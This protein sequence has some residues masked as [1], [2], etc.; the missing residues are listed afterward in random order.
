VIWWVAAAWAATDRL[1]ECTDAGTLF[2]DVSEQVG[3]RAH[4]NSLG[5]NLNDVDGD[6]DID[7]LVATG[8]SRAEHS[9]YLSG[10]SLLYLN[11]GDTFVEAGAEWGIDDVCEDR[12]PLFA[13]LDND[14][15]PDI[16]MTVNG[17]NLLLRNDGYST[18]EDVT[19]FAGDA[20]HAGW[21]H[22]AVLLDFDRDGLLDVFFTN[23]PEDG[24]GTNVLLRNLGDGVFLDES[25]A[26]GVAGNPSGKGA[27]VLDVDDDG[28]M[29]LF[30]TT[31]REYGNQLFMNQGDG[32]FDD[33]AVARGVSDPAKRFGVGTACEDLDNDGDPDIALITHD[34]SWTGNQLFRNDDGHFT[35][36]AAEAGVEEWVD[37]HG[38]AAVDLE[39]DG[40]LDLVLAGIGIP[41]V[42][43]QNQGDLTFTR[44][45]D[46]AGI[47][48]DE[49]VTWAV[50]AGDVLGQDGYPEVL[51]SN[52]LGRRPRS[53]EIFRNIG[54]TAHYLTVH[55][56][57]VSHNPSAV[58]ARV[59]VWVGDDVQTRWVGAFSSFDSQGPLP[60]TVGLGDAEQADRVVV[61]FTNGQEQVLQA[62][63]AD[64]TVHV[65][66]MATRA[67]DDADGVPDDW[68][69]C[70]FTA[71]RRPTDHEGCSPDQ[72]AGVSLA[73]GLPGQDAVA[74]E[75]PTWTWSG[76]ATQVVLQVGT[77]GTFGPAGRYDYGPFTDTTFSLS[78]AEWAELVEISDGWAPVIW[79][80]VG[81]GEDGAQAW[82]EPRRLYVAQPTDLVTVPMGANIFVP[83]HIVIPA[84]TTVTWWN[85]PVS[86][87]NLQDEIHDVQLL[88]DSGALISPM[89]DLNGGGAFTWTFAEAGT[90]SFLCHRH[91]GTGVNGDH[92]HETTTHPH[93]TGP[94]RCMAGTVTVQ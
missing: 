76:D 75:R 70:P 11:E 9:L 60:V 79:R 38:I 36:V 52:G 7:V 1:G 35:D 27:C 12:S 43:L 21:G 61:T 74:P 65:V 46:G 41:P 73:A 88:S 22:Q 44:L 63:E 5:L 6:G 2:V 28:W 71:L 94:Y 81:I 86:A 51:I 18:F 90:W 50:A 37:G 13:D 20:D 31:G 66:E 91:S 30:V 45:C 40:D 8:P 39:L 62:V 16:Y 25:D 53:N 34:K 78:D 55:V 47:A 68:D 82:T 48:Q 83:G 19:A 24:S 92:V 14:G 4:G 85:D 77:D 26:A 29:D 49:G 84:G 58:G 54:G 89:A 64:Q 59:Q 17:R 42:V 69:V 33:Q 93:A 72:R 32:T 67:D 23:G 56:E 80:L 15:L 57:G 3:M 87:G 10:E